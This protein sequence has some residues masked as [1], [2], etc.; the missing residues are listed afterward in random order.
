MRIHSDNL[1]S[2]DFHNAIHASGMTGVHMDVFFSTGSRRREVGYEVK[3]V[4]TSNRPP[5]GGSM[6]DEKA[7][8]WDEWGMFLAALFD[9]DPDMLAGPSG[10]PAYDGKGNFHE[11]TGHRYLTLTAADQHR[12]HKWLNDGKGGTYCTKCPATINREFMY[13]KVGA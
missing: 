13:L 6:H 7:A 8:T 12:N 3:L 9:A 10:R 4:G 1:N 5:M 2:Q 11:A